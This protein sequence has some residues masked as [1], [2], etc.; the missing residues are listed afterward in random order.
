MIIL[1]DTAT[2]VCRLTIMNGEQHQT[3]EWHADRT[4]ARFL[5]AFLRDKL[6]EQGAEITDITGIG[7][8]KGPGSFT[9]LRIGLTVANTLADGLN[10]PIV[11]AMGEDWQAEAL[12]R[13]NRGDTDTI[14]LP[15]YGGEAHITAPKR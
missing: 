4:L 12:V 3:H 8:M 14:V 15:E 1:L 13:L 9:G 6:A 5:L 7:V 11:G 2:P 10:V